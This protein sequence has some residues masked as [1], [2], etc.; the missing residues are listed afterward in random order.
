MSDSE[1]EKERERERD[2]YIY[3]SIEREGAIWGRNKIDGGQEGNR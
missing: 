3:M 2:I 1:S